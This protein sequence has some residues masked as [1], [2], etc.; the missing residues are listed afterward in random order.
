MR[1]MSAALMFTLAACA[2]S[3]APATDATPEPAP[4]TVPEAAPAEPVPPDAGPVVGGYG[5]ASLEDEGVKAALKVATDEIYKRE[6]TR[7]LVEK[8]EAEMQV[9]AGLNYAFDI[10]MSGGAHYK[11][12]VYRPLGD[13]PMEVTQFTKLN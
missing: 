12:V 1:L 7:A 6:P 3:T 9:V 4:A 10:T 8:T 13:A 2:P 11:V 5:P